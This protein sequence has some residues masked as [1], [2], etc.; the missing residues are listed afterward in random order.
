MWTRWLQHNLFFNPSPALADITGD[1]KLEVI[2]PSS[3][4]KLYAIQY[5]GS[6]A[7]GWPVT[8]STKTYTESSPVVADVTGDGALDVLLGDEDKLINGWN[9]AG[10]PLDGFPLVMKDA[11]RGTPAV[12]DLDINGDAEIVAVGYDTHGVR[13]GSEYAVRPDPRPVAD[14]ARQ[15][16]AQWHVRQHDSN[17]VPGERR[18]ARAP[19]GSRRTTPTRSIRRRRIAFETSD[20]GAESARIAHRLRRHRRAR[21]HA[22]RWIRVP[23]GRH[24]AAWDG[25][26]HAG[27]P[28]GSGVYFYRLASGGHAETRKMVLL[29]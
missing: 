27:A 17:R 28:A 15:R 25:R 1:G 19:C 4:G 23:G 6:D 26:N 20:R 7:P 12:V 3:N 22:G 29:K 16:P 13:V 21:A 14:G 18:R 5:N 2:I 24:S 11:M 10:V 8:Y 9:A